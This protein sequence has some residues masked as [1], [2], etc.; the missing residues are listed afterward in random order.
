MQVQTSVLT[1][2]YHPKEN[3][4]S[5]ILQLS[6]EQH[7]FVGFKEHFRLL[8]YLAI[9]QELSPLYRPS[10]SYPS[11]N[12]EHDVLEIV[13]ILAIPHNEAIMFPEVYQKR[14]TYDGAFMLAINSEFSRPNVLGEPSLVWPINAL[15]DCIRFNQAQFPDGF[16]PLAT[17]EDIPFLHGFMPPALPPPS[18]QYLFRRYYNF[19]HLL[20]W[21]KSLK[22]HFRHLSPH[23]LTQAGPTSTTII[24][25]L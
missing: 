7:P 25:G 21:I 20:P 18:K 19:L 2:L 4:V 3:K 13:G 1:Y 10:T 14:G 9:N 16:P 8:G 24:S 12:S 17:L 22:L 5:R 6:G 15:N 23:Q 11:A